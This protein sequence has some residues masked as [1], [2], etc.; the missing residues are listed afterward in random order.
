MSVIFKIGQY[1]FADKLQIYRYE[2]RFQI[3][4]DNYFSVKPNQ[5]N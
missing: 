5:S 2:C 1:I 3:K 4:K